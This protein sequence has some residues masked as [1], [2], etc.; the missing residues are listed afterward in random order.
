MKINYNFITNLIRIIFTKI[1]LK[2]K[3]FPSNINL[4]S[5][6]IYTQDI[7]GDYL[8]FGCFKGESF[9]DAFK[10]IYKAEKYWL[11]ENTKRKAYSNNYKELEY[12]KK[13]FK[14]KFFGFDSFQGLPKPKGIDAE[15]HLFKEGRYDCS[16]NNLINILKKA[17]INL[18]QVE[19]IEG[20]Y[21]KTLNL[22]LK[23]KLKINKA[24]IIMIDCDLY[25]S[26]ISVLNFIVDLLQNGTIIIFD[27]WY[28]YKSD[29]NK[30][31]QAAC[32]EWLEN[33]PNINLIEYGNNSLT[34]K[35]FI[36]N[37]KKN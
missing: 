32:K 6:Y 24:A 17:K 13:N 25:D 9:I 12:Y 31:E 36:V 14:R 27:D 26:T 18:E 20:F 16:K 1:I 28:N 23:Q 15:H 34:Q 22:N 4:A 29:P 30:G 33:N 2:D 37:L 3:I 35:M 7:E 19:L 21:D 10:N 8:E 5:N 11:S